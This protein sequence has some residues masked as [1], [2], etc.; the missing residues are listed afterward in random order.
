[1]DII[2]KADLPQTTTERLLVV[3]DIIE[4][5]P[6]RWDQASWVVDP[7]DDDGDEWPEDQVGL[8]GDTCGTQCC[9]AG[10]AV[11]YTPELPPYRGMYPNA[12]E[13]LTK[14]GWEQAGAYALGLE[15]KLANVM[16][17]TDWGQELT[18]KAL[19]ALAEMPEGQRTL[20]NL[21]DEVPEVRPTP[22]DF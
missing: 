3:A 6:D 14:W 13:Y 1:M 22:L 4:N 17:F 16:F 11:R 19:R 21:Y 12:P 5:H 9:I 7:G 8:D 2:D 15:Q 20:E 10:W 18:V